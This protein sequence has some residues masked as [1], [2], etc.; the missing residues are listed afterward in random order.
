MAERCLTH[1]GRADMKI[2]CILVSYNRPRW[3]RQAIKSVSDQTH[4][5]YQLV[6]IDESDVFD[7]HEAVKEF[8]LTQ[9]DVR[10]Y[11]VTQ[12]QR[13]SQNRLSMNL[14]VGVGIA[15]G[16]LFCFLA[17][18][19]YFYPT[20][21]EQ[22]SAFFD[23]H[24]D[25]Q[26]GFGK[27]VY[28]DSPDMVFTTEPAPVNLRFFKGPI[29]DPFNKIDHNQGI[30]RRFT[31]AFKWP[32]N[33]GAVGGPDAYYYRDIG[34]QHLFHAIDAWAAVKRVHAKNL[35]ACMGEYECG[36]ISGLRE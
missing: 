36:S 12:A 6:V 8:P 5:D 16:G 10:K 9:C 13:R 35:Q 22:A 34:K 15:D 33:L 11:E 25:V 26:A 19:D 28:S 20:W 24:P 17:D 31:P 27:L 4:K 14:N 30:H 3:V 23:S 18:D 21:F 29:R 1:R 2:S 7:I 32:E